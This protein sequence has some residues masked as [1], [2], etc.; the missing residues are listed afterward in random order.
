MLAW[1]KMYCFRN[2]H[3]EWHQIVS[4]LHFMKHFAICA[5]LCNLEIGQLIFISPFQIQMYSTKFN[6]KSLCLLCSI[7]TVLMCLPNIVVQ[8][9]SPPN[10]CQYECMQSRTTSFPRL[11]W[12]TP[13]F[14]SINDSISVS[15][16]LSI[17]K[18]GSSLNA[19]MGGSQHIGG[20]KRSVVLGTEEA[21][22]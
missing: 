6:L 4:V 18:C 21:R 15:L 7:F 13:D 10:T 12:Q 14:L 5:W 9:E 20:A 3:M 11:R 17:W 19:F 16:S 8:D 2:F 22:H 1:D